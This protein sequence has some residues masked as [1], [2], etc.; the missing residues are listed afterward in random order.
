LS[1]G[2]RQQ[3]YPFNKQHVSVLVWS[4]MV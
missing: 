3:V 2:S 1:T 4:C